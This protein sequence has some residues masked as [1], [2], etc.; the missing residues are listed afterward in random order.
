MKL[1]VLVLAIA[2]AIMSSC[3]G[4]EKK[5]DK[6]EAPKE[7]EKEVVELDP[8]KDKGIG[9]I[10]SITLGEIDEAMAAEGKEVFKAKCSA[11]HKMSK[12]FVGPG[13]AGVTE[14]RTPEW[15]MNMILNP[16]EMVEKNPAAKQLLAEYLSPMANQSLTEKEARLILEYFRTVKAE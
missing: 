5:K 2:V 4:D 15:I 3:G 10:S 14:R 1:K 11:C 9:P 6:V 12:R 7:A 16:E 13:L 8:M